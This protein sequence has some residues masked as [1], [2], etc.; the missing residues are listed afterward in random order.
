MT[1]KACSL[2]CALC[3]FS[4]SS[5]PLSLSLPMSLLLLLLLLLLSSS[6]SL[7]LLL[8]AFMVDLTAAAASSGCSLRQPQIRKRTHVTRTHHL[9]LQYNCVG[10]VALEDVNTPAQRLLELRRLGEGGEGGGS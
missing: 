4:L 5:S 1:L 9:I 7:L 10:G 3:T 8:S 2:T 6:S